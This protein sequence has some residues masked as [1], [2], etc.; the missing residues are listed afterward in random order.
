M[1]KTSTEKEL[2]QNRA[3]ETTITCQAKWLVSVNFERPQYIEILLLQYLRLQAFAIKS[4]FMS[5]LAE[6]FDFCTEIK[7]CSSF[8]THG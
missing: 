5:S 1:L 4:F 2:S 3:L 7:S 8:F 6:V